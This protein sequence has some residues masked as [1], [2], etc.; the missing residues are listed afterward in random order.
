MAQIDDRLERSV[1]SFCRRNE[2]DGFV[3]FIWCVTVGDPDRNRV[4]TPEA[5]PVVVRFVSSSIPTYKYS[6]GREVVI[7]LPYSALPQ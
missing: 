1:T 7:D 6:E 2:I 4:M 5:E 3:H